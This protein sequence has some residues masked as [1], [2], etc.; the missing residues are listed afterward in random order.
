LPEKDARRES[1]GHQAVRLFRAHAW[2]WYGRPAQ[3]IDWHDR[4]AELYCQ[5]DRGFLTQFRI[6]SRMAHLAADLPG[7]FAAEPVAAITFECAGSRTVHFRAARRLTAPPR[8]IRVAFRRLI[9]SGDPVRYLAAVVG[10]PFA[11]AAVAIDA[12]ACGNRI[13]VALALARSPFLANLRELLLDG[14]QLPWST[15][16][17]LAAG[18]ALAN[19]ERLALRGTESWRTSFEILRVRFGDRLTNV[20]PLLH[21]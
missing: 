21:A 1:L 5:Y 19:L 11:T 16:V 12:A 20:G 3:P 8:P 9:H 2:T 17:L 6:F 15:A 10:A 4:W 7:L 18:P 14:Y 13:D